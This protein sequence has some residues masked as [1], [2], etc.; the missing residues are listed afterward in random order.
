V[1]NLLIIFNVLFL[2][3][4][5]VLFLNAHHL[6]EHNHEAH[7]THECIECLSL[8]NNNNYFSEFN[9]VN[10]LQSKSIQLV[11]DYFS[12]IEFKVAKIYHSRA[13]PLS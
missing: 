13:P 10:S 7:N 4:G 2:L 6:N 9:N 3:A 11:F 12:A 8:E 1:K 5:N